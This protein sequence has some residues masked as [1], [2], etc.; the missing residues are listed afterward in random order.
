MKYTKAALNRERASEMPFD[1]ISSFLHRQH[2]TFVMKQITNHNA[3]DVS[4][5]LRPHMEQMREYTSDL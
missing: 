2:I 1:S 5:L 4:F 3:D